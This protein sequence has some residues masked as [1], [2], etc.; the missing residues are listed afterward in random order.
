MTKGPLSLTEICQKLKVTPGGGVKEYLS[1]LELARFISS[2][3][4]IKASELK[5]KKYK[6][7][8]EFIIFY[9]QQ[10]SPCSKLIDEDVPFILPLKIFA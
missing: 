2:Y 7:F 1:N 10:I 8:D 5:Y 9:Y 6:L 3:V 4:P